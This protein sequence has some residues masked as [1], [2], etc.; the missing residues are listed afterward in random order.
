MERSLLCREVRK[1]QQWGRTTIAEKEKNLE[2]TFLPRRSG[3]EHSRGGMHTRRPE[4]GKRK[5]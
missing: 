4:P 2:E 3:K 5:G 1:G